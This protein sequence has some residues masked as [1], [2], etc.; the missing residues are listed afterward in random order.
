LSS[1][2]RVNKGI[3]EPVHNELSTM[4]PS[5]VAHDTLRVWVPW[6]HAA[7]QG[8]H[9]ASSATKEAQGTALHNVSVE[10]AVPEQAEL[11]SAVAVAGFSS[12]TR[13]HLTA[14]VWV[15]PVTPQLAEHLLQGALFHTAPQGSVEQASCEAGGAPVP[16]H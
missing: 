16:L 8:L 6:P 15:P 3:S 1:H 14:R 4:R 7:L 5:N 13:T 12:P 9:A 11:G 2:T 10:G